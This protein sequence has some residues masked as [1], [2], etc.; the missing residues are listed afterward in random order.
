MQNQP[1]KEGAT[2]L[3]LQVDRLQ[4]PMQQDAEPASDV[5]VNNGHQ[6][7]VA[8]KFIGF[9]CP[10]NKMQSQLQ[11]QGPAMLCLQVEWLQMPMQQNADPALRAGLNI[12]LVAGTLQ[13]SMK[14]L[15]CAS[16]KSLLEML[17][18]ADIHRRNVG[19]DI[20]L[21]FPHRAQWTWYRCC[22][23]IFLVLLL[24]S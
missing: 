23:Y 14:P 10:W 16:P 7:C 17:V 5:G 18:R 8:C 24:A 11:K 9:R 1:Q 20:V 3:C 21:C 2:M 12:A 22:R 13:S 4:M 19:V 15:R 6:Q